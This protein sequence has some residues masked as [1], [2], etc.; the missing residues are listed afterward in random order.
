M[1]TKILYCVAVIVIAIVAVFNVTLSLQKNNGLSDLMMAN[2][3]ALAQVVEL[4][5]ASPGYC[6]SHYSCD[7]GDITKRIASCYPC[8]GTYGCSGP[9]HT[10]TCISCNY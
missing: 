2:V 5:P 6:I 8:T 1:K 4:P 9:Y 10:H 3:E 7:S